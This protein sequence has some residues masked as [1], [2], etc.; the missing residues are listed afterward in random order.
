L[1]IY[2]YTSDYSS[3]E[4]GGKANHVND[5]I[6]EKIYETTCVDASDY[7]PIYIEPP[8]EVEKIYATFEGK[9]FQ[10]LRHKEIKYF[11]F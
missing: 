5:S 3:I 2:D 7:G 8:T 4:I 9:R 1:K 10:K 11:I 6:E